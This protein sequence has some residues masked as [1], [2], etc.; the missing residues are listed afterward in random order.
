MVTFTGG[1]M[2]RAMVV[3]SGMRGEAENSPL[4]LIQRPR[5][6]ILY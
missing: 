4:P 6:P 5:S 2:D 1:E 3:P